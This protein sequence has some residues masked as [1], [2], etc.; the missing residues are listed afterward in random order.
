MVTTEPRGDRPV[1]FAAVGLDHAHVFGQIDGLLGQGCELVGV[2]SDDKSAAVARKV[3]ERWPDV[4]WA[5]DAAT[6]LDA[7]TV[8]VIVTAA[9]PDRRAA[10]AMAAPRNDKDVVADKPG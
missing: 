3:V 9:V 10:N 7:P 2:F 6:L 1:R 5:D 8:D 4:E